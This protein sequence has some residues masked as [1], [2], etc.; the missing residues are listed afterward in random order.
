M[1]ANLSTKGDLGKGT[2]AALEVGKVGNG[3]TEAGDEVGVGKV[4]ALDC[5]D[6]GDKVLA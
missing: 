1:E 5:G 6:V 2:S 4:E 3:A